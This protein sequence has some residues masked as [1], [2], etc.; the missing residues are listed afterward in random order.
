MLHTSRTIYIT[1]LMTRIIRAL[2][3]HSKNNRDIEDYK[4]AHLRIALELFK[5]KEAD[6]DF[7]GSEEKADFS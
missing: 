7:A 5:M 3:S 2:L 6:G 1:S 4:D